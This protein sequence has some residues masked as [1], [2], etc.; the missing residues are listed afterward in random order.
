[1]TKYVY[2]FIFDVESTYI[3]KFQ[4]LISQWL[5]L[6]TLL[7]SILEYAAL[8]GDYFYFIFLQV[9]FLI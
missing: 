4:Q 3:L 6:H 2:T 8:R 1:M 7:L 9:L 5:I